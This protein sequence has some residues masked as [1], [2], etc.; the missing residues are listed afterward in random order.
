MTTHSLLPPTASPIPLQ[1]AS[2]SPSPPSHPPSPAAPSPSV[3]SSASSVS[4]QPLRPPSPLSQHPATPYYRHFSLQRPPHLSSAAHPPS[5]WSLASWQAIVPSAASVVSWV[6][7]MVNRLLPIPHPFLPPSLLRTPRNRTPH[8]RRCPVAS[9]SLSSRSSLSWVINW[10]ASVTRAFVER[11]WDRRSLA[12][13]SSSWWRQRREAW[14]QGVKQ[15]QR[16]SLICVSAWCSQ[17][18]RSSEC[19]RPNSAFY[20]LTLSLSTWFWE[21]PSWVDECLWVQFLLHHLP[22][23]PPID[24]LATQNAS[25]SSSPEYLWSPGLLLLMP[26]LKYIFNSDD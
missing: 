1:I 12:S 13:I 26:L 9:F 4:Q 21:R 22:Q 18:T 6:V 5:L 2:S 20:S 25:L 16:V 10:L 14:C 23:I 7:Q 24:H 11:R 17:G 19:W 15:G 8:L 3:A